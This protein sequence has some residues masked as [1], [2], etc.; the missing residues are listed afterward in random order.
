MH[1]KKKPTQTQEAA[2]RRKPDIIICTPGRM[3]DLTRNSRGVS[4][5][6]IEILIM[7]EADRLLDMGFKDEIAQLLSHIPKNRQTLLFSATLTD[8]VKA[9][10]NVSLKNAQTISC[11]P[12][13]CLA[14]HLTQVQVYIYICCFDF[15]KN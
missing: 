15:K 2:L 12:S 7:D 10:A 9:L 8:D 4:L 1:T 11:D 14:K 6:D 3:I 13:L 5:D